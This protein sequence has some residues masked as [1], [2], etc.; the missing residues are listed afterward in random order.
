M[1]RFIIVAFVTLVSL[2]LNPIFV[3]GKPVKQKSVLPPCKPS[4]KFTTNNRNDGDKPLCKHSRKHLQQLS[5][6]LRLITSATPT[7]TKTTTTPTTTTPTTPTTTTPTTTTPTTTPTTT[8]P[9]T[10]T[11]PTTTTSSPS[12]TTPPTEEEEEE[13]GQRFLPCFTETILITEEMCL[14]LTTEDGDHICFLLDRY[15]EVTTCL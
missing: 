1:N 11:P 13:V 4:P 7:T 12:P 14:D 2:W 10:T 5:P 8:T 9:T 15:E 6:S 3:E